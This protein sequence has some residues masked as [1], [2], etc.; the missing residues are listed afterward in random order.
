MCYHFID[1]FIS[2]PYVILCIYYQ[3]WIFKKRVGGEQQLKQRNCRSRKDLML[4]ISQDTHHLRVQSL[5]GPLECYDSA[6]KVRTNAYQG[7]VKEIRTS[8]GFQL[9]PFSIAYHVVYMVSK[10]GNG[11]S[12]HCKCQKKLHMSILNLLTCLL[13]NKTC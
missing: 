8:D 11:L 3:M 12:W 5:I 9:G 13:C 7:L 10:H 6:A 1:D 2:G 4:A